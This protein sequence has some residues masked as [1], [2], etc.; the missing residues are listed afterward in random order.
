MAKYVCVCWVCGYVGGCVCRCA[1]VFTQSS[2]SMVAYNVFVLL[3]FISDSTSAK[4]TWSDMYKGGSG[5]ILFD[6]LDCT[7]D[8][9]SLEQCNHEGFYVHDCDHS[10]DVGVICN[11]SK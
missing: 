9:V 4:S 11:I 2:F 3:V 5:L 10:E 8:E 6:E 7:G 1:C